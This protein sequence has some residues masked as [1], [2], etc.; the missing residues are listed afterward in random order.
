MPGIVTGASCLWRSCNQNSAVVD[1]VDD[2][3]DVEDV[4]V[5]AEDEKDEEDEEDEEN[6]IGD[7]GMVD[8]DFERTLVTKG[9][10]LIA[11]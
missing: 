2:V 6:E 5:A 11:L 10:C 4:E 1:D 8:G 3:D 9:C 7:C